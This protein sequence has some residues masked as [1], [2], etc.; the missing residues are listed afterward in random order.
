M[1]V[2]RA[3]TFAFEDPDWLKKLLIGGAL[4]IHSDL[5]MAGRRWLLDAR[6]SQCLRRERCAA[7]GLGPVR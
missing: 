7:A 5:R 1:D 2:G 3:F 6:H 4:L